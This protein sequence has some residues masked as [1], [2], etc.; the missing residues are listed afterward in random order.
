MRALKMDESNP[1]AYEHLKRDL[2]EA[3]FIVRLD[4]TCL[5]LNRAA[6]K[7]CGRLGDASD[8]AML[9]RGLEEG[10]EALFST[11]RP[12]SAHTESMLTLEEAVSRLLPKMRQVKDVLAYLR[13]FNVVAKSSE[14]ANKEHRAHEAEAL[15]LPVFLR[16]T[17]A[18][19][20]LAGQ[21]VLM[22]AHSQEYLQELA[23][24]ESQE[25]R[26]VI[27]PPQSRSRYNGSVSMQLVSSPSDRHYQF[28]RYPLYNEFVQWFACSWH[29][30]DV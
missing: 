25:P 19:E 22:T 9:K 16:C 24:V 10:Q 27:A 6:E 5:Y 21:Q 7:F 1:L 12:L 18:A 20:P 15:P 4:G 30:R 26:A 2:A 8:L 29:V 11:F 14:Q 3:W 17:I 23:L 28:V 13:G